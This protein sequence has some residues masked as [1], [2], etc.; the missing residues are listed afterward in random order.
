MKKKLGFTLIEVI[1]VI[2]ILTVISALIFPSLSKFRNNRIL[3]NSAEDIV[4]LLNTAHADTVSSLNSTNYGVKVEQ[5]RVV[6]FEGS[7]F[8]EGVS[9]NKIIALNSILEIPSSGG[10]TLNSGGSVIVFNRLTGDTVNYGTIL[11]RLINDTTIQKIIT[12]TKT[13]SISLN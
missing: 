11:I 10:V 1:I 3:Q 7:T 9:T 6:Y 5:S 12:V 8:T 4:S 13:G 2:S